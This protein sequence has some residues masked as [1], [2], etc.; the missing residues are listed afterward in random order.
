MS[1]ARSR[2][3]RPIDAERLFHREWLGLAQPIEGLVFSVPSLADAQIAPA[4]RPEITAAIRALLVETT[5]GLALRSTRALF[6]TFLGYSRDGMLVSRDALPPELSFYAPESRQHI[7]ASFAIARTPPAPPDDDPFAA[8]ET[9]APPDQAPPAT[10]SPYIA[11]VWDLSDDVPSGVDTTAIDLDGPEDTTGPWRYPPTAKLER[12]LRH[13]GI[14]IGFVSNRRHLRLVYAPPGEATSHLTFRFDDLADP[15]GRPLALALELLFHAR[16]TYTADPRYTFEGLLADS[17]KRQAEVTEDLAQQVFEAVER[18]LEGFEAAAARDCVGDRPDW[19]RAAMEE[20]HVYDGV[21]N[22]VLRLVFLLYAEDRSLLPVD[23]PTYAAHLSVLGLYERLSADAGAHPES[24]HQR[25]GAYGALVSLFRAVYFGVRHQ[26]LHLPPRQGRLFDP[27]AFPFL[28]GGLPDWTAA[29]TLPE[30]RA[31]VRLPTVDDATVHEVLHR[32]VVLDGQRISYRDLSVEQIGAVY[33]SLMGF[34]VERL[35]GPAVRLGKGG[36]WLEVAS[37]RAS[38]KT[39]RDKQLADRCELSKNAITKITERLGRAAKDEGDDALADALLELAGTREARQRHRART[40]QLVLQPTASRRSTGSHYT[41]RS[42]SEKVVRRTL[43]PVLACLG[44]APTAAQILQLK[45]CDPAMGSGAFLVE[46]CRFLGEAVIEAWRRSGELPAIIEQH[47]DATL[48]AK[49]LVAQRCLY[50]VDKNPAAVELAKL[51][52]WLETLSGDKAF[53][54]LDHVLRHGDSLVGLDL[55][56]IRAFHWSPDEQL[57]TIRPLV[58]AALAEVREHREAI[59]ALADD[60]SDHAQREKRRLLELAEHAMTRVK[61]VADA[62]VGAFFAES[63]P[64]AREQER[65]RRLAV[66]QSYLAGDESVLGVLEEWAKTIRAQHAPFHWHLELPEVFF[67]ERPDPLAKGEKNGAAFVDAFVGN[68]PFAGKNAISDT[69]GPEYLDWFMA[70]YPEVKGRPNTDLCAYFFR[71]VS[72]LL[73]AHGTIGLIATNTIAQGDSRLMSLKTLIESGAKIYDA[74]PSTTWPGAAA[75]MIS[76]V[77]IAVGRARETTGSCRL[78][79][80]P[81]EALNSRLRAGLERPDPVPLASNTN[82]AFMGGKLVGVGLAVSR[83]EYATLVASDPR[84]AE[85]LR[86]YLGGEEVNSNP[87]ASHDR[88]MIDFSTKTLDEAAQWPELLKIAEEKVRPAR[89]KDNRGTYKTYWWRPGESGGALYAA[90]GDLDRCLVAAN[91]SKHL[92]LTFQPTTTFFSQTLYAFA[93]GSYSAFAVLQ[94]RIHEPWA[95]LLSSSMKND[96]RYAA[97]D[98]FETFPFPQSDPRTVIPELEDIGRR[99]YEARAAYM[100]ET[101][102]GLTQTYNKLKDPSCRDEPI[103]HLRRLHEHLDCAVLAAYGWID[104]QVPRFCPSTP[105]EQTV[106]GTFVDHIIDR[107]FVLNTERSQPEMR[108]APDLT[109][110]EARRPSRTKRNPKGQGTLF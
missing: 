61:L 86:P 98:C 11:L 18:L 48:H 36:H 31:A 56:Q 12:L 58:D 57:S 78:N 105:E 93:L 46:A 38:T 72:E 96:L 32:L 42:L 80:V 55:D 79:D 85:V 2:G 92:M 106:L 84:N 70:R 75:V 47:G 28:E 34:R 74:T 110:G 9:P 20:G 101:Q 7:R 41:P 95:R 59:Q 69:A 68:P 99:L 63:K 88:F 25:Y 22:V 83:E 107:L 77:N 53:T 3:G 109:R 4:P 27:S 81:V 26:A 94:S 102:Q 87:D 8:F 43:G 91:V 60:E 54:F 23:H 40:G 35:T 17:R 104:L 67:L 76:I 15:A 24:M 30:D 100:V 65:Q 97:S 13:T 52:L 49:R 50:G 62:C 33:E 44:E 71:R 64:K 19:L 89:E 1:R 29:V 10:A 73:G 39:E 37:L 108:L 16:R 90:L 21:L 66:V 6:E 82:L 14:P 51:S 103:R 45:V 5:Q